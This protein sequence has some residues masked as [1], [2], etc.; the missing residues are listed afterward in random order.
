MYEH[1]CLKCG[2]IWYN[3]HYGEENCPFCHSDEIHTVYVD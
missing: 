1:T 3:H 2:E